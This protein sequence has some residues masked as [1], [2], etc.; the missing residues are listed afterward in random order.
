MNS[1]E[2]DR[3]ISL[4]QFLHRHRLRLLAATAVAVVVLT[5][6]GTV[7]SLY[8]LIPAE[9]H[10]DARHVAFVASWIPSI[11]IGIVFLTHAFAAALIERYVTRPVTRLTDWATT[12]R[13]DG[14]GQPL[15]TFSRIREITDLAVALRE[16]F[17]LLAM[18]V[19][20]IRH[21]VGGMRH[22]LRAHLS[23][24]SN[25]AQ[26][27]KAGQGSPF[28]AAEV[29]LAE[30]RAIARILDVN[31]EIAK[32]FSNILGDPPAQIRVADL[33]QACLDSLDGLADEKGVD[34]DVDYPPD[35]LVVVAHLGKIDDIIHNLVDNAIKYTPV[36][37]KV[38]LSVRA[39][40]NKP[41]STRPDAKSQARPD[42]KASVPSQMLEIEVADTGIGIPDA[43]KPHVFE[44]AFRGRSA[45]T[46]P[47][48]G[49]GL[50][51]VS[52]IMS[53]YNGKAEIRDNTPQGTV[54]T[55]RLALPVSLPPPVRP[56]PCRQL[57]GVPRRSLLP[58]LY[59]K[60]DSGWLYAFL[61]TVPLA[62]GFAA[63]LFYE[64]FGNMPVLADTTALVSTYALAYVVFVIGWKYLRLRALGR[65][66]IA[67]SRMRIVRRTAYAN[68]LLVATYLVWR[69][70][71]LPRAIA[72]LV[73]FA[74]AYALFR[75][76]I[77]AV[78]L[79]RLRLKR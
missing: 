74:I 18:R 40:P 25:A 24:I 17:D 42:A 12:R 63:I 4:S 77:R 72:V 62:G 27:A 10:D 6:V 55:I 66:S 20:Q 76:I 39:R 13:L 22:N 21:L 56:V 11:L 48:Y 50:N 75:L 70:F 36:G 2:N 26:F 44:Y 51:H 28:E 3:L 34:L 43:D 9:R 32:N 15:R 58:H 5:Y 61:T 45:A 41:D 33:L 19:Q 60:S 53:L 54:V 29:A 49:Y 1:S 38:R 47:G 57:H 79:I 67:A 78:R 69:F 7:L 71:N 35:D 31:A 16:L 65:R 68:L 37:G 30:V 52:S 73:C 64:W 14:D 23:H 8:P 59:P 46:V